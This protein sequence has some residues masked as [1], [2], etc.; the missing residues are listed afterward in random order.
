MRGATTGWVATLGFG[1][2]LLAGAGGGLGAWTGT[3]GA[4][5]ALV[6]VGEAVGAGDL[7]AA[8]CRPE[9]RERLA[10]Q[11]PRAAL[12]ESA[13]AC[14]QGLPARWAQ[15]LREKGSAKA[16]RPEQTERLAQRRRQ[17]G[18]A[19]ACRPERPE[20]QASQRLLA[21]RQR[22]GALA[23]RTGGRR[24]VQWLP[25]AGSEAAWA[26]AQRGGA[27]GAGAPRPPGVS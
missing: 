18:S 19:K 11:R 17:E 25:L 21:A 13:M 3:G 26:L 1:A 15:R 9:R 16:C 4:V 24:R 22:L 5:S 23:R 2:G 6:V 20:R 8:A 14:R 7:R 12:P 10:Q 27:G